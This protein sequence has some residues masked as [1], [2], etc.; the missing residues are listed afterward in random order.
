M[1]AEMKEVRLGAGLAFWGDT[2]QPAAEMAQRGNIDYLCCD[3]LAELT[4]SILN[5]QKARDPKLGYTRD[6]L[7]LLRR[8]LPAC[9]EQGIKVITNAGGA[10]P[11]ACAEAIAELCREL[12]FSGV[13]IA[14]VEG[15]DI[16]DRIDELM[17]SGVDF[18][19]I[20]TGEPLST[21]RDRM[22][23]ANVYIGCEGIVEAL[24][25]DAD[26]VV[27]G[28]VTD[29]ALY[30]GPMRHELGWADDEWDLL[31]AATAISHAIECGGQS[32]GG[33]YAGGWRKVQN[34]ERIGYPIADVYA[35][36]E[37]VIT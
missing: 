34:L 37:A 10:N 28:R 9:R 23:H 33:L 5:K 31:G 6:I 7:E 21:V 36:G 32:T 35:N 24:E 27:C 12:G 13:K 25:R 22:T 17:A 11:R 18:A 2:V 4:M 15:D 30:I 26:I 1:S 29:M 14:L 20:D 8:A 16:L 19:N 3:H